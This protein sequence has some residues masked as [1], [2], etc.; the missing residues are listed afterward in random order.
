MTTE[1]IVA[2]GDCLDVLA[3]MPADCI[4]SLVTDPPY[5]L[6]AEP[7]MLSLFDA[8]TKG[9]DLQYA[10]SG[11]M[12]REWDATVPSPRYWRAVLRVLKPGALGFV[13]AGSRTQDL[14]GLSLSLAGFEVIDTFA[15][16]YGSGFP[17]S[18]DVSKAIDRAKSPDRDALLQVT[19]WIRNARDAAGLSNKQIDEVFGKNG[20]AA[21]WTSTK[22]QP[23]CPTP[24]QWPA[25]CALLQASPTP[26]VI[27]IVDRL[28]AQTGQPGANWFARPITGQHAKAAAGE[29]MRGIDNGLTTA[30]VDAMHK[31]E[32]RDVPA[33]AL[34]AAWKGWGTAL[35]PAYEPAI[36]VRKPDGNPA[37]ALPWPPFFYSAK[38]ARKERDVGCESLPEKTGGEATDREDESEGL[39]SPRAGAGRGG[40]V[41]NHHPTVKPAGVMRRLVQL[42]SAPASVVLDP[43]CGSGSTG[44]AC[45]LEGR[46]FVGIEREHGQIRDG[47]TAPDY[48][49][50]ARLRIAAAEKIRKTTEP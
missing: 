33:T 43:F 34:A 4:D 13:F 16:L 12:N 15:W 38:V 29:L 22:S 45:A 8:W 50:I 25:L 37:P 21:H 27:A 14:M 30:Q 49:T 23:Y 31:K 24:D 1:Q 48:V 5:G 47:E 26:P 44:I 2:P 36:F 32:Q 40:G 10:K 11:F 19:A 6:G 35:K 20:M 18:L 3:S 39:N 7:D 28:W 42:A 41:R 17:K 46:S 9:D